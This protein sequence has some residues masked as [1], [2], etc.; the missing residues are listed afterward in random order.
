MSWRRL[1]NPKTV[2][3]DLRKKTRFLIDESLGIAVAE[4]LREKGYNAVFADDVGL[5]GH[6]DEDVFA[7]AWRHKRLLWTHDHDFLDNVRFPEHRNP[8]VV[9]LPG[10]NGDDSAMGI[11]IGT[12]LSVFGFAPGVWEKTKTLISSTGEMTI[13]RR[14]F[15]T[16]KIEIR[17]FRMTG[18]GYAQ[19]WED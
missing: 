2:D 15:D 4:Y 12:A 7:Y 17:R 5:A 8:G 19:A 18:K 3:P 14:H 13:R 10:A 1:E 16:G 6:S 11:G 9:V